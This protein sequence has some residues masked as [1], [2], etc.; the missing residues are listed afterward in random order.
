MYEGA[1]KFSVYLQEADVPI[2]PHEQCHSPEVHGSQITQDMLCAG[3][4]EGRIDACQVN[5]FEVKAACRGAFWKSSLW[6]RTC[7]GGQEG[8]FCELPMETHI[9]SPLFKLCI[10]NLSLHPEWRFGRAPGM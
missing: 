1:D 9:W 4:L 7:Q 10:L 3:Y 8:V 5:Q 6:D 2:I